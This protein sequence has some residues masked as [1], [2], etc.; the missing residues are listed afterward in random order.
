MDLELRDRRALVFGSSS[1]LGRAI[2]A[3]LKREGARVAVVSRSLDRARAALDEIGAD[4]ALRADLTVDGDGATAVAAAAAAFGGLDICVVNTGGGQPGPILSTDGAD[5]AAY[6]SMLRP[7]L[8]ISR[9]AAPH[10][11]ADGVG[12]L[13]FL[14]S[15][16]IVEASPDL[17]LSSVFRSGVHAAAR[18]LAIELAPQATVNVVV[19]GQFDTPALGR[20]ESARAAAEG[21]TPDDVRHEN[22]EAIPMRRLGTADELA[23]VVTFLC[24]ARAAYVTGTALR[25]DGGAVRGF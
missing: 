6:R 8:E 25:I 7:A 23:D 24:S 20:F 11:T 19:T 21:R 18:S 3:A 12:R 9:A 14:T 10:V 13:V 17:A 1:G 22:I 4:V 16:S 2:A 15:R 5:D